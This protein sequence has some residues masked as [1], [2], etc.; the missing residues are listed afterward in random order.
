MCI[1][2][3]KFEHQLKHLDFY[4]CIIV[5]AI[6]EIFKVIPMLLKIR[7]VVYGIPYTNQS[8]FSLIN[9]KLMLK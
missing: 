6:L 4:E 3:H 2:E 7:K 9:F 5:W 8:Y 1:Q